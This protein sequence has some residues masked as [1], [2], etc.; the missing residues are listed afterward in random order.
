M[1]VTGCFTSM[2]H[3]G[4]VI[5]IRPMLKLSGNV[6]A[7]TWE[8]CGHA[9]RSRNLQ[10]LARKDLQE[11]DALLPL[12]SD[13][14]IGGDLLLQLYFWGFFTFPCLCWG[15]K[16]RTVKWVYRQ[17]QLSGH[18]GPISVPSV[19]PV[20]CPLTLWL[21]T[22]RPPQVSF[23]DLLRCVKDCTICFPNLLNSSHIPGTRNQM[24][25]ILPAQVHIDSKMQIWDVR[26]AFSDYKIQAFNLYLI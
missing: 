20:L 15:N 14:V 25:L 24:I 13:P 21:L 12:T 1:Q 18:S 6:S 11:L 23:K 10:K 5:R 3:V 19:C 8:P 9:K 16:G 2:Q 17:A 22:K 4:R 26:L 7:V